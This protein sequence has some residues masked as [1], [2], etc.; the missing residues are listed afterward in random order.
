MSSKQQELA[1]LAGRV[2][3]PVGGDQWYSLFWRFCH[4]CEPWPWFWHSR[5]SR[6]IYLHTPTIT[7]TQTHIAALC[8][9]S[10]LLLAKSNFELTYKYHCIKLLHMALNPIH[11]I[12]TLTS[13][14]PVGK[15][16]CLHH[17]LIRHVCI[18][19]QQSPDCLAVASPRD[20]KMYP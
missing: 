15:Y 14:Y 5:G 19:T 4:Y 1:V 17:D 12:D 13:H 11:S 2:C 9:V 8:F 3:V 10:G 18:K 7:H 20:S 6:V 16:D